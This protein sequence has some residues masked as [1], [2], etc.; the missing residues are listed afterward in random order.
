MEAAERLI[1]VLHLSFE[2]KARYDAVVEKKLGNDGEA[3]KQ[4]EPYRKKKIADVT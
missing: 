3:K 1:F 2:K 4:L